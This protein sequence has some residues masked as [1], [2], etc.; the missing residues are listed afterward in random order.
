VAGSFVEGGPS[1]KTARQNTLPAGGAISPF[2]RTRISCST[3][4]AST[5]ERLKLP[6]PGFHH[7]GSLEKASRTAL[8]PSPGRP[9]WARPRANRWRT[10]SR[11]PTASKKKKS[12]PESRV[13]SFRRKRLGFEAFSPT[14]ASQSAAA[15]SPPGTATRPFL[16]RQLPAKTEKASSSTRARS[17][18]TSGCC[19]TKA[20]VSSSSWASPR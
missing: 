10:G 3:S 14:A 7:V 1:L 4:P 13:A 11:A 9:G 6:Q 20:S 18:S 8:K 2:G 15:S 5:G 17:L 12:L 19:A 16:T